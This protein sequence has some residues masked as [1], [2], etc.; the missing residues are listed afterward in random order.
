MMRT[1][2]KL[3][4]GVAWVSIASLPT[5]GSASDTWR[6]AVSSDHEL[7]AACGAEILAEGGNAVDAAVATALCSGVVQPAGSGLGGGG[8]AVVVPRGGQD[9]FALD[10][11]EVAPAAAHRDLY[12]RPDGTLDREGSQTGGLAVAVPSESRGLAHLLAQRGTWSPAAVVAPAVRLASRGFR[13]GAH[14]AAALDVTTS[15]EVHLE[16][17]RG[18]EGRVAKR[19]AL[20]TTLRAWGRTGGEDLHTGRGA[21]A[22]AAHVQAAGGILTLADLAAV[23]PT[24]RELVGVAWGDRTLLTM[25]P[26]SSGGVALAQVLQAVDV[27]ALKQDGW[28]SSAYYHR[29]AEAMKHAYA[30]RAHFLGDP[31]VVDVPVERLLSAER[32]AAIT[33]DFDPERTHPAAHYAPAVDVVEDAGTLHISVVDADGLAVALTTTINTAFGAELV[34]PTVGIVLNDEMDDFALAP[35]VPNAYGLVGTE[36]NA[37]AAGKTPLSSMTPTVVLDAQGNVELVVGASGGSTII[38]STL[39][40]L[41]GV[42]VFDLSAE[43]AVAAPRIHHQWMPDLLFVEPTVPADVQAALAERGHV[44]KAVPAYSAVQVVHVLADG[45]VEAGADPRKGGRPAGVDDLPAR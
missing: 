27:N 29:L 36:A 23:A 24:S 9:A 37:V 13:V 10:F 5:V 4:C 44:I 25:P 42:L 41:L 30:D 38:S 26:P 6:A 28:G 14:L 40:V 35:G 43:Q 15:A 31:D 39:Q 8:F 34:P 12:R 2:N 17:G 32:I 22:V 11:R 18:E 1:A 45:R 33:Q 21:A 20:A 16:L 7:A 3:L 19:P